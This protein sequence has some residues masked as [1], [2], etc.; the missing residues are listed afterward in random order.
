M[1]KN[2]KTF[3]PIRIESERV[4]EI[5][6]IARR[7]GYR[8]RSDLIRE[9]ID[10]KLAQLRGAKILQVRNLSRARAKR[11]ILEYIRG[12]DLVYASDVAE[13]LRLD[14]RLTFDVVDELFRERKIEEA[15]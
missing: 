14:L 13:A 4:R 1:A 3:L 15:E 9:A 10:D 5:D 12:K 11:E 6:N 8:S 2:E 7:F